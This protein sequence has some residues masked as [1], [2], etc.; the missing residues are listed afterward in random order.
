MSRRRTTAAAL[1]GRDEVRPSALP[2]IVCGAWFLLRFLIPTESADR[3]ETLWIVI[4]WLALAGVIAWGSWRQGTFR[5]RLGR[6]EAAVGLIVLGHIISAVAV[7]VR[8]EQARAAITMLWEWVGI[9]VA[10]VLLRQ[11]FVSVEARR[12]LTALLIG[13]CVLLSGLGLWQHFV[14]YPQI[15]ANY[16]EYE[17]LTQAAGKGE[18]TRPQQLR[19]ETL[20]RD[21]GPEILNIAPEQR[22]S[23]RQRVLDSNEP[24]GRFALANTLGGVLAVGG[25]LLVGIAITHWKRLPGSRRVMFVALI[26]LIGFVLILTKSR[27][28]WVGTAAALVVWSMLASPAGTL[29]FRWRRAL[30]TLSAVGGLGLI[31]ATL[32]FATGLLDR[33]VFSEAPKSVLY[34]LQYWSG[35]L[36]VLADQP[37]F[38]PGPGNF[39]SHYLQY[40]LPEASEEISDPHNLLLDVWCSGG[41]I[42]LAGLLWLAAQAMRQVTNLARANGETVQS[43][44]EHPTRD[45]GRLMLTGLLAGG[46]TIAMLFL[47]DG[48]EDIQLLLLTALWFP[49]A[50][51]AARAVES[52]GRDIHGRQLA[53]VAVAAGTALGLHLCG[54]GGMEMPAIALLLF[55][56]W[57]VPGRCD[58]SEAATSN[59]TGSFDRI[60]RPEIRG[61]LTAVTCAA[62][63]LLCLWTGWRP[64]TLGGLEIR[65][66]GAA[67]LLDH[68]P[69]RAI[70]HFQ[71]AAEIDPLNPEPWQRLTVAHLALASGS[72]L[73][74]I[75]HFTAAETAL[76]EAIARDPRNPHLDRQ[77]GDL[78]SRKF[79]RHHRSTDIR[80]AVEA[81]REA[82]ARYPN[83]SL[84]HA[85]LAEALAAAGDKT[86]AEEEAARALQLDDA[87]RKA[88]HFDKIFSIERRARIEQLRE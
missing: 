6:P 88:L 56:L 66:G 21:L 55:V 42:A 85:E 49:V 32:A 61:P 73:S 24:F 74:G 39:R 46:V 38:G 34:R 51:L 23:L 35:T 25:I 78:L 76:R 40:K 50:W 26:G 18:L 15:A 4:G 52:W 30:L 9:A 71:A 81:Y 63:A 86:A 11:V 22:A 27:T 7:I 29:R 60:I 62:A 5:L 79:T 12:R 68:N 57:F 58:A 83:S 67:L 1:A 28:A 84:I 65:N 72:G 64:V 47:F 19:L 8:G 77:L 33:F 2:E 41:L 37:V 3:G 31:V 20:R 36:H 53:V 69:E 14:W 59:T 70:R 16:L 80:S 87:N 54:A 48:R 45:A 13:I 75:D 82:A 17:Q 43:V 44:E 10:F